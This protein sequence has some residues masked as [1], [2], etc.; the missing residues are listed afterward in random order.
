MRRGAQVPHPQGGR[1]AFLGGAAGCPGGSSAQSTGQVSSKSRRAPR[2]AGAAPAAGWRVAFARWH[3][4]PSVSFFRRED[5]RA[6]EK[7]K[8]SEALLVT[9]LPQPPPLSAGGGHLSHR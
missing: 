3:S 9:M 7:D 1:K 8:V 4:D 5:I 2:E 6:T